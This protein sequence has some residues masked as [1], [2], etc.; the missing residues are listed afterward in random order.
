MNHPPIRKAV[1]PVAGLGT[2]FLPATK[3]IPKEMLPIIDRPL[4]DFAVREAVAAGIDTLIFVT[5][6]HKRAIE[7]HFDRNIELE[8]ALAAKGRNDALEAARHP[9]PDHVQCLFVRQNAP[10]GLGHA[11]LQAQKIIGDEPFAVLL[12]DDYLPQG[13]ATAALIERYQA[14]GRSQI[15]VTEITGPEISEYG[16][17]IPGDAATAVA[18]LIEKP[19]YEQ[20]PSRLA[21]LGRYVLSAEILG[22][23]ATLA[24]GRGGE[25]QLADALDLLARTQGPGSGLGSVTIDEPRFD[26]GSKEGYAAALSDAIT[27][28]RWLEGWLDRPDPKAA[29][30]EKRDNFS[31]AL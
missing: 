15:A 12:A 23:L 3:A 26:C 8:I 1:F 29:R 6:R 17:V 22:I 13:R 2:R 9:L 28:K 7:D 5:G 20:A 18:G 16:V 25:V 11:V 14:T 4:I 19:S 24:P 21:S 31:S 30:H 27:K 10:E